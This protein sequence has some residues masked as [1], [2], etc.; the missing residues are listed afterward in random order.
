MAPS[1]RYDYFTVFTLNQGSRTVGLL[2]DCEFLLPVA[3]F[4]DCF[5]NAFLF[6]NI[7]KCTIRTICFGFYFFLSMILLLICRYL[8]KQWHI[9]VST[10]IR[11]TENIWHI[12][13]VKQTLFFQNGFKV[14]PKMFAT[15]ATAGGAW[16]STYY[17]YQYG[18]VTLILKLFI[19]NRF[20]CFL[21][22]NITVFVA[23]TNSTVA[24]RFVCENWFGK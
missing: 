22:T 10:F 9:Y 4:R 14:N 17:R 5:L 21:T 16:G 6:A 1:Q 11:S 24:L 18:G 12:R 2:R 15:S 13:R 19:V 20:L 7:S 8:W 23:L 3:Y